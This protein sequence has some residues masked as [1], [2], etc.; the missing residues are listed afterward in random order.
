V[1]EYAEVPS[2][3]VGALAPICLGLPETRQE[4]AWAGVRW[5]VRQ[6]TFAQVFTIE[7][8]GPDTLVTML[9]FRAAPGELEALITSGSPFVK[10][11]WG[12]DVVWMFLTDATD[13]DEVQELLTE[14]YC[15]LAPKKLVALVDRP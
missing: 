2:A 6:R 5:R 10:A 11:G 3:I 8:G 7:W 14:S 9:S 1:T 13:W 12:T 4:P 15:L